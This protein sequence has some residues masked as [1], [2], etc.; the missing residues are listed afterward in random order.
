MNIRDRLMGYQEVERP[1]IIKEQPIEYAES[2]ISESVTMSDYSVAPKK[3]FSIIAMVK[4]KYPGDSKWHLYRTSQDLANE[5][6]IAY[7][8]L[9]NTFNNKD[10]KNVKIYNKETGHIAYFDELVRLPPKVGNLSMNVYKDIYISSIMEY[11]K[12]LTMEDALQVFLSK[13]AYGI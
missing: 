13:P 8:T 3:R 6:Q 9:I 4:A 11:D 12:N 10:N 2:E 1:Q 5:Q 7:Q